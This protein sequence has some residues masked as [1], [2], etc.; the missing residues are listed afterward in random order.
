MNAAADSATLCF[1]LFETTQTRGEQIVGFMLVLFFLIFLQRSEWQL[2]SHGYSSR[3]C[4]A[5]GKTA[6]GEKGK[7]ATEQTLGAPS[8]HPSHT[9]VMSAQQG[10]PR[11]GC[12]GWWDG[13]D[14][15]V[16]VESSSE[17]VAVGV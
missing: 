10:A 2:G 1:H 16:A 4:R 15:D 13:R 6:E 17:I 5:H 9:P 14:T 11:H 8:L 12:G 3:W 7:K